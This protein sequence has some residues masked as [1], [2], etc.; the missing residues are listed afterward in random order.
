VVYFAYTALLR[1]QLPA[2]AET[3]TEEATTP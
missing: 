3:V 1:T 2:S